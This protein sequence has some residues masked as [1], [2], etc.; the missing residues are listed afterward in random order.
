MIA[1]IAT[2]ERPAIVVL[3]T[4]EDWKL[5]DR[6]PSAGAETVMSSLPDAAPD[7]IVDMK[8]PL[9]QD[10]APR[11]EFIHERDIVRGNHHGCA[12]FVEFDEQP[13]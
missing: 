12:G 8:P 4:I 7:S 9:M 3:G 5:G 13:Q 6:S 11:I 10:Q 1:T 2:S